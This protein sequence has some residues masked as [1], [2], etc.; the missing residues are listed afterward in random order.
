MHQ[1]SSFSSALFH[2]LP[3]VI[4]A[5]YYYYSHRPYYCY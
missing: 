4:A 1:L 2:A 5:A 3:V